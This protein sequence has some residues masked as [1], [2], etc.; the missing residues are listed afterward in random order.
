MKSIDTL[1]TLTKVGVAFTLMANVLVANAGVVSVSNYP[2][3]LLSNA[4]TGDDHPAQMLLGAGDVGHHG[5]LSPSAK[6]LIGESDYVVWFGGL[7]EQNL[8]NALSDA[9]NAI[10]LFDLKAFDRLPMRHIDGQ[11]QPESLDVHIWLDPKNAKAV[12]RALAVIH[13]HANPDKASVYAQ[14]AKNF[15]VRMDEA[16]RSVK[17]QGKPMPYWAYHDSFQYLEKSANLTFD[18]ALTADH[19][20]SPKASQ[21]AH[22]K[23]TRPKAHMCVASQRKVSDGIV[24]KLGEVS[25]VVHQ[26]DMSDAK[27]FIQGWVGLVTDIQ[28]CTQGV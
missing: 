9:P 18:G 2:L 22:L 17:L 26:E 20:L 23:K 28:R 7:L 27:D 4:V 15:Q 21:I 11:P 25:T 13:S 1:K 19:H 14:N 5:E 24:N 16:V 8:V 12:V 10:S 3:L 6:K